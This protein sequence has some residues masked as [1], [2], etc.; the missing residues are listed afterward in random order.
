M[1]P[2]CSVVHFWLCA[3]SVYTLACLIM[4][5]HVSYVYI[6]PTCILYTYIFSTNIYVVPC[7][8]LS[9]NAGTEDPT[10]SKY[11]LLLECVLIVTSV[12]PPELPI[13][14]SL[15]VNNSLI[16]LTKLGESNTIFRLLMASWLVKY[17]LLVLYAVSSFLFY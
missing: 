4:Y 12:V 16:A 1:L 5:L 10:R 14:L 8:S 3:T 6:V 11:K 15:A 17:F 2:Y 9:Q 13:E 7:H